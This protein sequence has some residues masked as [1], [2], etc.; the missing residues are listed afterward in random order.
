MTHFCV[1]TF[2]DFG[3][4][5]DFEKLQNEMPWFKITQTSYEVKKCHEIGWISWCFKLGSYRQIWRLISTTW[6]LMAIHLWIVFYQLDVSIQWTEF[7]KLVL[8]RK[9]TWFSTGSK[10]VLLFIW[11]VENWYRDL[12]MVYFTYIYRTNQP[13][14]GKN[15]SYMDHISIG[16][17]G[18]TIFWT[19]DWN[20]V[21]DIMFFQ[22]H[23]QLLYEKNTW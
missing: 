23:S 21:V 18:Y 10:I 15:M 1:I 6:S 14:V 19:D 4:V 3:G 17:I 2:G 9:K 12:C 5:P 8:L 20:I 16:Y 7:Q 22:H 11:H 13:M